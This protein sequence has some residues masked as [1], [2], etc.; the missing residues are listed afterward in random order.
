MFSK[1]QTIPVSHL[2]KLASIKNQ[3][4]RVK[5]SP[6]T[7][8]YG[9]KARKKSK[10][11][12]IKDLNAQNIENGNFFKHTMKTDFRLSHQNPKSPLKF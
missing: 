11:G 2:I 3:E 5:D 10:E 9:A 12:S 7:S 4:Q 1:N 8:S 6:Y